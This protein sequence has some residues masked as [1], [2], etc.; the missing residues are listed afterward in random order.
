MGHEVE[1]AIGKT[2]HHKEEYHMNALVETLTT[3][4]RR[5]WEEYQACSAKGVRRVNPL[6]ACQAFV[7][8]MKLASESE[9]IAFTRSLCVYCLDYEP[10]FSF[11]TIPYRK[12]AASVIHH[13]LFRDVLFPCLL[14]GYRRYISPWARRLVQI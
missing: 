4:R 11:T 2:S 6:A 5:L 14:A 7:E 12:I 10:V 13:P 9:R 1:R 8:A 3:D